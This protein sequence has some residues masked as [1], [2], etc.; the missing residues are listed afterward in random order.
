MLGIYLKNDTNKMH[1]TGY[2][3]KKTI[4]HIL[5]TV[6][7]SMLLTIVIVSVLV[8]ILSLVIPIAAQTIVNIVAFGKVMQPIFSIGLMVFILM[9][10]IGALSIWQMIIIEFIQQKLMIKVSFQFTRQFNHLPPN[11]F[12]EHHGP[13]LVNRFFDL[14]TVMK[15]LS[16]LL[17]YGIQIS[18]QVFFGFILLTLYHPI[19]FI[20][21]IFLVVASFFIIFIPYQTALSSAKDECQEKHTIGAWLMEIFLNRSLFKFSTY[22]QFVTQETDKRLIEFLKARN[23]HFKQLIRHQI[24]F[25]SLSAVASSLLLGLGGYLVIQNQL[26]LGQLV[27]SEIVLSNILYAFK[28]LGNLLE[29][30]Y[31][32]IASVGKIDDV[33][34]LPEESTKSYEQTALPFIKKTELTIHHANK[35]LSI[36]IAAHH[37]Y[38][39]YA[40][41]RNAL[42]ELIY[43]LIGYTQINHIHFYL[44]QVPI[45]KTHLI[46]LRS[47]ILYMGAP[48]WF[49]GTLFENLAFNHSCAETQVIELLEK[50]NL[51]PKIL[52][53]SDGLNTI[54]PEWQLFFTTEEFWALMCIRAVIAKPKWLI[55]HLSFDSLAIQS[56]QHMMHFLADSNITTLI[57]TMQI[58]F[59]TLPI[60][61]SIH[62]VQW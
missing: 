37:M 57:T 8:S 23:T 32:L 5:A 31:D 4:K 22:P 58:P 28:R 9:L 10:G 48:E 36:S 25:F 15:D 55:L 51:M 14:M 44:N 24:G 43:A 35:H 11:I 56:I 26:S 39:F 52:Q 13:Q 30:Y 27:A 19:F 53:L 1:N 33:L 20:F 3:H 6:D 61:P 49:L 59:D 17:L 18:L 29:N 40:N 62:E 7:N 47:Y 21:N 60:I 12:S 38:V 46:Q 50:M 41:E 42:T 2:S 45:D 54:I 16:S 34:N